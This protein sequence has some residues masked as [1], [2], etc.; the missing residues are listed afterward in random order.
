MKRFHGFRLDTANQCL[1]RGDE[2]V[3][4]TPKAFDLLR[5][6]VD[7]ANRLVTQDE[8]LEALWTD[9]F[10]N[11]EVVKKYIL[12]IRK[13]LG[14]RHD[15][16]EFIRTF[17]K[18]GYQ[19]VAP[20]LDDRPA[21]SAKRVETTKPLV[22][23]QMARDRLESFVRRA[24]QGERQIV[25]VTGEPG[26]GKTTFVD[27][28][29]QSAGL[30]PDF[31]IARGQCVEGFGGQEAYY[32]M[33]TAFEQLVHASDDRQFV[34]TLA[35]RAPTWL[36]QFPSLVQADQREALHR[37]TLGATRER[38][39]REICETLDVITTDRTLILVLEDLHWADLSTLDVI[40]SCARRQGPSRLLLIGTLRSATGAAANALSRLRQD[41]AIH[42]LCREIILEPFHPTEVA[43][44]LSLAFGRVDFTDDL[45][46]LIH[47]HSAGNPL[48]VTA[49]V[50]DLLTNGIVARDASST[51]RL[52]VPVER[53]EPTVPAT[54]Q[55]M[56]NVQF[57][58][59]ADPEQ[60][61]LRRA[62][63]IGE[64]F[65]AWA[66]ADGPAEVDAVER[67]CEGLA[68][69]RL[70]IRSAGMG[71]LADGTMTGFYEFH[72]ALYRHAVYRRL[73]EVIRSKVHRSIGERLATLFGPTTLALA[74][75]L[76][77]HF[78]KAHA[79][80]RAIQYW[81]LAAKNAERRFALRESVDVLQHALALAPRLPADRRT[82]L[83][84]QLLES[85]GDAHYLLGAMVESALA[86]ETESALAARSGLTTAQVRAQ[87]CFARPLGLLDP[88]RAIAVLHDAVRA[89][90]SLD[91]RPMQARIELFAAGMRLLYDMWR[92][93]DAH[94]SDAAYRV[95]RDAGD[96]AAA[97]FERM[98]Y[99][100]LQSLQGECT[101][102]LE[103]ARAAIPRHQE[104]VDAVVHVFALS[105]QILAL[106]QLGR[107]GQALQVIRSSQQTT[108]RNGSDPWLFS[109]REAWL[110]TLALDFQGAQRVCDELTRSSVYPSG[111]AATIGR[112]AAGFD[113][114]DHGRADE[115][116]KHFENVRDP[117]Q[118]PKFFM[119]WYWRM[120]AHVGLV[121]ARLQ[122]A[123]LADAREEADGLTEAAL[124]I[125]DPNLQA[126]AWE[127]SAQ[128]AMA[129][130]H[131]TD[132]R[133][134]LERAFAALARFD[135]PISAWRVH[136]TASELHR[137]VGE[138]EEAAAH[139]DRARAH[140]AALAGSFAPD[141][142]LRFAML[143]AAS[144]R[145]ACED[146]LGME[147]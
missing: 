38:M 89:S 115:A 8:I 18:R 70:F 54:L 136:A 3:S 144:V 34:H 56:L 116:R 82:P 20:I 147:S 25:F 44:Y 83:E 33:L 65:S 119:H 59:L 112:L 103:N 98:F 2:R 15:K 110:R 46:G 39:V 134:C 139:R 77:L 94:V 67:A 120:H 1:W 16:P 80:E 73:S 114:L 130:S 84:I 49:L 22:D 97:G 131:W 48:F 29:V 72:H 129:E 57:D 121:R 13:V 104:P 6:L 87:S 81:M 74:S 78:E 9:T 4:L 30:L 12:G 19:F 69:R 35:M 135:V 140:I 52:T 61:V 99:A 64:R 118:T 108:K 127:A 125:G 86:Y 141:E 11:Q 31:W 10:V 62:S 17:P 50:R 111:Q 88:D 24:A 146:V 7:H 91:D 128:V 5:Y 142:P 101:E 76:A 92:V 137:K 124:G 55:D 90:A 105:A 126:L 68:E 107:F 51:W 79:Y 26:V 40:S 45:A 14:D 53:I 102:A 27:L 32:P 63:A 28:F 123:Q 42:D 113:A 138:S 117:A 41:L 96:G 122:S 47:R 106:L 58:Q 21:P 109:Y 85:I 95:I 36:L 60:G 66:I 133:Q 75:E 71:E 145:R 143:G 100:H 93:D 43:E 37:D 132:A 23:R